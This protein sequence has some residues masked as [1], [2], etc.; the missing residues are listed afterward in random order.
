MI[1]AENKEL[2]CRKAIIYFPGLMDRVQGD[3]AL[4]IARRVSRSL[5]EKAQIEKQFSVGEYRN[6]D[7]L[8]DESNWAS[9]AS[10][11]YKADGETAEESFIDVISLPYTKLLTEKYNSRSP[12]SQLITLLCQLVIM[13]LSFV[14]AI[15]RHFNDTRSQI[16]II[17]AAFILAIVLCYIPILGAAIV[18]STAKVVGTQVNTEQANPNSQIEAAPSNESSPV[19]NAI[20]KSVD[21]Q[22]KTHIQAL[23]SNKHLAWFIEWSEVFVI[24]LVAL[25]LL[26]RHS[27]KEEIEEMSKHIIAA[28]A[29]LTNKN[30]RALVI[31]YFGKLMQILG[32][33]RNI[34]YTE[35]QIWGYSFGSVAAIDILW[36]KT[37]DEMLKTT[38]LIDRLVTIGSPVQFLDKFQ[39]KYFQNRISENKHT[40]WVNIYDHCDVLSTRFGK[41]KAFTNL[42]PNE[43]IQVGHE[44]ETL[45]IL[46][47]VG[48]T[49][50][51]QYWNKDSLINPGAFNCV[52]EPLLDK[53]M[54]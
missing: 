27:F 35:L 22:A 45:D 16:Q 52:T 7:V 5:D 42:Q 51:S 46:R 12:I 47:F 34:N 33:D 15:K 31:D 23:L 49:S 25:G 18:S 8:N 40:Q 9:V 2:E 28:N 14:S 11:H 10:I 43:E 53:N 20:N 24:Y 36:P 48:F 54:L 37:Q 32:E 26:T 17:Y 6:I 30:K 29:Y 21:K 19:E 1:K 44:P 39:N 4:D 3:I 50:H 38:E 41:S 13:A